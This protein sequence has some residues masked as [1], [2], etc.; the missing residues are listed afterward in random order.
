M[1][2]ALGELLGWEFEDLDERIEHSEG[3]SVPEIFRDAGESGFRQA[4]HAALTELLRELRAGAERVVALG[5]GAFAE[6]RNAALIEAA[7]IPTVFL[8]AEAEE[9]WQRC[10]LQAS[11]QRIERPLLD[12]L[13]GFRGL[14]GARRPHYLKATFRQQTS[15]KS[16]EEIAVEVVRTLSLDRRR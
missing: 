6:E 16:V 15:G 9:L 11:Q 8:D 10:Q 13:G 12:S 3:R 4:E 1:G 7:G 2:R 5:G 14:Y